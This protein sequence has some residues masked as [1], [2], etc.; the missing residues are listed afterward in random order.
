MRNLLNVESLAEDQDGNGEEL[1][2]RLGDV[3]E[4]S[5]PDAEE[6]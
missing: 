3:D 4:M 1:L 6:A 2:Q 5:H